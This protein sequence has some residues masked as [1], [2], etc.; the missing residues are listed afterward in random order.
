MATIPNLPASAEACAIAHAPKIIDAIRAL[1][2]DW[3]VEHEISAE[4]SSGYSNPMAYLR[5]TIRDVRTSISFSP[6][7]EHVGYGSNRAA[8]VTGYRTRV[9]TTHG[10]DEA[11]APLKKD[12]TFSYDRLAQCVVSNVQITEAR[13]VTDRRRAERLAAHGELVK[14]L[15]ARVGHMAFITISDRQD[16]GPIEVRLSTATFRTT[17]EAAATLVDLLVDWAASLPE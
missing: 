12:G 16:P 6:D 3:V 7:L 1:Q 2:P 14:A 5:I 8:K 13:A 9:R 17:P 10:V 4:S 11:R 15:S